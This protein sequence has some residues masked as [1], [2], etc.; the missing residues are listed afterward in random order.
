M[1]FRDGGIVL[2]AGEGKTI[3]V[4]GAS[5]TYKAAKEETR[6]AYALIE[7]TVV[8]DGPPPAHP[9]QEE[10]RIFSHGDRRS[11]RFSSL[12]SSDGAPCSSQTLNSPIEFARRH[13]SRTLLAIDATAP[14]ECLLCE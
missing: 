10:E 5:Y 6:G 12:V 8:S 9:C 11:F 2:G 3:S 1:S 14:E 7:H 13:S 4:L